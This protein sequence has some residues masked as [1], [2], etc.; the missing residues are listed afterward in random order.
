[1]INSAP[2]LS[3]IVFSAHW[4][5]RQRNGRE[6]PLEILKICLARGA[7]PDVL[8]DSRAALAV[9]VQDQIVLR[10]VLHPVNL[11]AGA[12][13]FRIFLTA[14]NRLW[15]AAPERTL[16]AAAISSIECPSTWRSTNAMRSTPVSACIAAWSGCALPGLFPFHQDLC[17]E[18]AAAACADRVDQDCNLWLSGKA[19]CLR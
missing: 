2:D 18:V 8:R 3:A 4:R 13:N 19:T 6:R 1:M 11:R 16:S 17:Q 7:F 10:K 5:L 15:R 14:R 12:R 9:I